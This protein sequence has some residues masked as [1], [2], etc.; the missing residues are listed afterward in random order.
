MEV[1]I[2]TI[3]PK[4]IGG[5]IVITQTI[6]ATKAIATATIVVAIIVSHYV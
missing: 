2:T 1:A 4:A 5:T 3:A 6:E